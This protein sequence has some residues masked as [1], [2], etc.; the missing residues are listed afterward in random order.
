MCVPPARQDAH[1]KL[2]VLPTGTA[3]ALQVEEAQVTGGKDRARAHLQACCTA[4]IFRHFLNTEAADQPRLGPLLLSAE[5]EGKFA[6][7]LSAERFAVFLFGLPRSYLGFRILDSS[8][9]ERGD[10]ELVKL[11]DILGIS[12]HV[13]SLD[14]YPAAGE[15]AEPDGHRSSV[16]TVSR[17]CLSPSLQSVKEFR[18]ACHGNTSD[19]D[20]IEQCTKCL[21]KPDASLPRAPS[22]QL[23]RRC[24]GRAGREEKETEQTLRQCSGHARVRNRVTRASTL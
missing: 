10:S 17:P 5:T 21:W 9:C 8:K 7:A 13:H 18:V 19:L 14:F 22:L 23:A 6:W 11:G 15:V 20:S 12:K 1:V 3:A 2:A 16:L 4:K 24:W